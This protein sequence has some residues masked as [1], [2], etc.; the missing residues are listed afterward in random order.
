MKKKGD[1]NKPSFIRDGYHEL[2]NAIVLQAVEDFR[3]AV[4]DEKIIESKLMRG[5]LS[6]D[7]AHPKIRSAKA[8][9]KKIRAFFKSSWCEWLT[10]MDCTGLA[11]KIKK[12]TL[13]FIRLGETAMAAPQA[14]SM[15]KAKWDKHPK[16]YAELFQNQFQCPTC[17]GA[18]N[19]TY[20]FVGSTEIRNNRFNRYGWRIQCAGCKF[21][22]RQERERIKQKKKGE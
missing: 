6:Y 17:G 11:D 9:Q 19:M 10:E 12:D 4:A 18:V 2:A 20:G 7:I 1:T 16:K 8:E 3:Y 5:E 13:E 15:T 22:I 21:R 14:K